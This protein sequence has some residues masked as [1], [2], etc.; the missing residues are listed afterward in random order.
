MHTCPMKPFS[1]R[2]DYS[3]SFELD[4]LTYIVA[5]LAS[6]ARYIA[7]IGTILFELC[8]TSDGT[9]STPVRI[10]PIEIIQA[11][12]QLKFIF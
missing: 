7:M 2:R 4:F 10:W 11:S 8:G 6:E 5:Q 1:Y 3:L 9:V 12:T